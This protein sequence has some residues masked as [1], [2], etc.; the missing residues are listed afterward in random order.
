VVRI[1]VLGASGAVGYGILQLLE[2]IGVPHTDVTALASKRSAGKEIS[3]GEEEVLTLHNSEAFDFEGCG[4]VFSALSAPLAQEFIPQALAAG[5]RVIDKSSAYR[6]QPDIPLIVPEVNA[7]TL[8]NASL[9]SS[10]NCVAIPLAIALAP[11][12]ELFGIKHVF[13]ATYQSVS[14][15]GR[16]GMDQLFK[17]TRHVLMSGAPGAD[18]ESPFPAQIAMNL[19]PEIGEMGPGGQTDEETKVA[20]ETQKILAQQFPLYVTCTRVPVI[21]GHGIAVTVVLEDAVC[22]KQLR[23]RLEDTPGLS[24]VRSVTKSG[25]LPIDCAGE[26]AVFLA[27][28]RQEDAHTLSFWVMSDNLRKGAALNAIHIAQHM[29]LIKNQQ[30]QH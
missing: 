9:V 13:A 15:A 28:L 2:E 10:P 8:G 16:S 21:I 27:R 5:A 14:G 24:H 18:P 30:T 17:E 26:D 19:I 4:L 7:D 3:F 6:M 11:L 23:D 1:A 22:M 29:G 12:Q 20:Q 25:A